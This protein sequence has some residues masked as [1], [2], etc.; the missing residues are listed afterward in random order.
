MLLG[1]EDLSRTSRYQTKLRNETYTLPVLIEVH[2]T[3]EEQQP[4]ER[5]AWELFD[6]F[7]EGVRDDPELGGSVFR[8]E[9]TRVDEGEGGPTDQ[10][11]LVQLLARVGLSTEV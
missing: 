6:A 8:A 11:W 7:E 10:G 5:R 3:G 9:I 1:V 2:G 4:V